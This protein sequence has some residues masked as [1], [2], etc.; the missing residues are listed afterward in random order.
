MTPAMPRTVRTRSVFFAVLLLVAV[1]TPALAQAGGRG[2][3][4]V[5]YV[6][7]IRPDMQAR[8]VSGS[9]DIHLRVVADSLTAIDLDRGE[10]AIEDVRHDGKGLDF[11]LLPRRLRVHL[12]R[13]FGRDASAVITVSYRGQPRFGMQFHP[14]RRQVY[15]IFSTSQWLVCIDAPDDKATLDLTVALPAGLL[16]AGPGVLVSEQPGGDGTVA[17]RWRQTRPVSTFLYG[18]AAG[19]FVQSEGRHGE[20][21]LRYLGDGQSRAELGR[22]FNTTPDMLDFFASRAGVDYPDGAYTQ[23]LVAQT[24]GQEASGFSMLSEA[25]G[26]TL[27]N[28]PAGVSL[29][30]HELAH[31]WWGNLVTCA[32]WRHFWLNEGF[33][34]FMAAAYEERRFGPEAYRRQIE[35]ARQ[36][37]EDVRLKDGDKALVFANWDRPTANDR[38]VVYQKGAYVLHLL[39]QQLGDDVFWAGIRRYTTAHVGRSVTTED[40]QLSMEESS[41][42]KLGSFFETWVYGR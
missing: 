18:F 6:A 40:F 34:T 39:R 24:A 27:L 16:A 25:Y 33:A 15:T 31:Q 21:S 4:V 2:I 35:R 8:S 11:E 38:T 26:R 5:G 23:V 19:P 12:G 30:A 29:M 14:E 1:E 3:D 20:T 32:D 41:G 9:V 36:R 17:H 22:I 10:L 13:P 37:Y 28:E 42:M 7:T